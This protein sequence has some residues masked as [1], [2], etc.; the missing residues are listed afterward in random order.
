[1]HSRKQDPSIV[2]SAGYTALHYAARMNRIECV[3]ELIL[4][5]GLDVNARMCGATAL[6]RAAYA[7][8]YVVCELLIGAGAFVNVPDLS[9]GGE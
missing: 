8:H 4:T 3:K 7:G 5:P 6:H 9:F 2:D 1:M